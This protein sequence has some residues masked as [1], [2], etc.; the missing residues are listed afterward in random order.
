MGQSVLA[1]ARR[2][3]GW[4]P[5]GFPAAAGSRSIKDIDVVIDSLVIHCN[6]V[7]PNEFIWYSLAVTH[8]SV[9]LQL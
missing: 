3:S 2:G 7:D 6:S 4:F 5:P 8:S 1:S 9:S